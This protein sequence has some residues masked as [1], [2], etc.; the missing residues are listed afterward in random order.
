MRASSW[1]LALAVIGCG[2]QTATNASGSTA[3]ATTTVLLTVHIAGSG[4]VAGTGWSC[5]TDCQQ[6]LQGQSAS[7]QALPA[8]GFAFSGWQGACSGAAGCTVA[9]TG[10]PTVTAVFA[11]TPPAATPPATPPGVPLVTWTLSVT[12]D[13]VSGGRVISTPA[14]IDCTGSCSMSVTEGTTV[15]LAARADPNAT[16]AG[17]SGACG[18][19][20]ACSLTLTSNVS[21]FANF[22]VKPPPGACVGLVPGSLPEA[23]NV[24]IADATTCYAGLTDS[25]GTLGLLTV[26]SRTRQTSFYNS[27]S[28]ALLN[29]DVNIEQ[30]SV[31]A[32]YVSQPDGFLEVLHTQDSEDGMASIYATGFDHQGEPSAQSLSLQGRMVLTGA[33]LGGALLSGDLDAFD[34]ETNERFSQPQVCMVSALPSLSWC[35][36]RAAAGPVYGAGVDTDNRSLV[37]TGGAAA[38]T[39]TGQWFDAQGNALTGEFTLRTNFTAGNNTWFEGRPLIGG[40]LAVRRVDQQND[41]TG[42]PYRTAQWL[43]QVDAGSTEVFAPPGWLGDSADTDLAI[44]PSGKAYARLPM[45]KPGASCGPTVELFAADGTSCASITLGAAGE[46]CRTEDVALGRDGTLV[47]LAPRAANAA[48][49]SCSWRWWPQALR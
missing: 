14:G 10:T 1:L 37:I 45:G 7:L 40:G 13:G 24:S 27:V 48:V 6:G 22:A 31:S 20:G 38:G 23:L 3:P 8:A 36:P 19:T 26:G 25:G 41:A 4:Q 9:L 47:E 49:A 35:R 30:E 46:T 15:T 44:V 18:G 34:A 16:F 29:T 12:T 21:V 11:A 2:G 33:P 17:W 28:G 43:L 5:S 39:I 42:Y 32:D